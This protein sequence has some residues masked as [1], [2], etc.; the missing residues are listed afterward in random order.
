MRA[1]GTTL[2]LA[3][4]AHGALGEWR[5][6]AALLERIAAAGYRPP[7]ATLQPALKAALGACRAAKEWRTAL[8]ILEAHAHR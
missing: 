8:Q 2:A 3:V 7:A 4:E 5:A 1:D 6:A